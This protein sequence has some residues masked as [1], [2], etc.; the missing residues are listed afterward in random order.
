MRAFSVFGALVRTSHTDDTGHTD[1]T[2]NI[3]RT[4]PIRRAAMQTNLARLAGVAGL[5]ISTS[6]WSSGPLVFPGDQ[7]LVPL[8]VGG[9]FALPALAALAYVMLA[10][11]GRRLG[12]ML[13][14]GLLAF[15]ALA[16]VGYLQPGLIPLRGS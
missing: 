2:G 11:I 9:A 4:C 1:E 3:D 15:A 13:S 16:L 12:P 8:I 7:N 10:R 6:A 5:M 14:A